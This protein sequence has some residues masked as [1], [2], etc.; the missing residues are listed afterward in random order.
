MNTRSTL[1]QRFLL[2]GLAF[3]AVVIGG[4]YATGRELVEFFLPSGPVGGLLG[5]ALTMLLWSAVCAL[6]FLFALMTGSLDYRTF[7]DRLLGRGWMLFEIAYILL[8]ALVLSVFGAAAGEIGRSVADLPI[9]VG[10]ML[11]MG[12]IALTVSFGSSAVERLFKYVSVLLYGVYVVFFILAFTHF[13]G[14][15]DANLALDAPI[16]GWAQGGLAYA[17]YNVVGAIA[18]LPVVRH[19]TSA[20]DAV[21]AGLLC[22]PLAALPALLFFVCMIPFFPQIGAHALPSDYM[23]SELGMPLFQ[24]LFQLMIFAALLEGGVGLVHALNERVAVMCAKRRVVLTDRARL[25]IAITVLVA[26]IFIAARFGLITLIARGYKASAYVFL[27]LY[28]VPLCTI[29]V[30]RMR[31]ASAAEC[32]R[33]CVT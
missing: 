21:I 8:I 14:R 17:G 23:L 15:I 32:D 7:F 28:V 26:S 20:R 13:H 18:I 22:G 5:I 6:T 19:F 11:L 31:I 30:W 33:S 4:G 2:P 25:A 29:G 24:M 27:M 12:A 9:V 1:F 10:T 16:D 3:K